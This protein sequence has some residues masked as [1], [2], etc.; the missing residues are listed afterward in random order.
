[1]NTREVNSFEELE[2][3]LSELRELLCRRGWKEQAAIAPLLFR[4]QSNAEWP[5][6]TTLERLMQKD[7]ASV[8]WYNQ[9]VGSTSSAVDVLTGKSWGFNHEPRVDPAEVIFTPP[10]YEYLVY[11]RHHGFPSP[12]LD[13]TR[14]P[15][16]ALFFAFSHAQPGVPVA[17]HAF[18]PAP[19]GQLSVFEGSPSIQP[20]GPYIAAHERHFLQQSQY[21][22]CIRREKDRLLYCSHQSTFQGESAEKNLLRT[23][24]LPAEIRTTVLGRLDQMNINEHSLFRSVEG[25]MGALAFR[26]IVARQKS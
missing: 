24:V 4:G 15:Y 2:G 17:F 7:E 20:L 26:E 8:L 3:E 6:V 9:C 12:L 25:L 10:N 14:S 13:W 23:F 11:C 16:V 18:A 19:D 1:M 21:T 5:I 22:A